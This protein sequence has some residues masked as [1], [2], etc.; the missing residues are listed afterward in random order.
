MEICGRSRERYLP[1]LL[2]YVSVHDLVTLRSNGNACDPWRR[3]FRSLPEW[4]ST[5]NTRGYVPRR[6]TSTLGAPCKR[7]TLFWCGRDTCWIDQNRGP[8]SRWGKESSKAF[9]HMPNRFAKRRP[10]LRR[11]RSPAD[12]APPV[13]PDHAKTIAASGTPGQKTCYI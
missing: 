6:E 12:I 5:V 3:Y 10:T 13:S 2:N 11:E 9:A 1:L 7:H 4:S 8:A